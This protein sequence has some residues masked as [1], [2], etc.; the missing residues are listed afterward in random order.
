MIPSQWVQ[1]EPTKEVVESLR[2]DK[3]RAARTMSP[4]DKLLAGP[5]L[6]DSVRRVMLAGIRHQFPT[7]GE[8]QGVPV[9]AL[10]TRPHPPHR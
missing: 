3:L 5:R 10:N 4:A 8:D 6:F 2:P 7:A 9:K 1:V